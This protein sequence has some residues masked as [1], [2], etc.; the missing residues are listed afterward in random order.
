MK[1]SAPTT[2]IVR[3]PAIVP[4]RTFTRLKYNEIV[5]LSSV[6]FQD[7][8]TIAGNGLFDCNITS[9]GTQPTGFDQYMGLYGAFRVHSSTIKIKASNANT[10]STAVIAVVPCRDYAGVIAGGINEV[11]RD[12][13]SRY[14]MVA[15]NFNGFSTVRNS[16][17]SRKAFG[18]SEL[19]DIVYSGSSSSNPNDM[20]YWV[21]FGANVTGGSTL[22]LHMHVEVTYSVEFYKRNDL[23][24]S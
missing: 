23:N 24:V 16:L 21:I 2:T 1:G 14:Q 17:S 11:M 3:G 7:G 4:D 13:R 22:A 19:D 12:P 15:A 9:T 20:W 5:V 10:T 18:E 6:T 8:Y